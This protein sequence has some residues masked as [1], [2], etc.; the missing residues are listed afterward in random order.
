MMCK[1]SYL[2]SCRVLIHI[3]LVYLTYPVLSHIW[4]YLIY[5]TPMHTDSVEEEVA[6]TLIQVTEYLE[7]GFRKGRKPICYVLPKVARPT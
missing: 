3:F 5:D 1:C 6:S 4:C 7:H 2:L